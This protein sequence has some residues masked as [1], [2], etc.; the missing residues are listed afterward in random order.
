MIELACEKETRLRQLVEA[1]K[2]LKIIPKTNESDRKEWIEQ[3]IWLRKEL[4]NLFQRALEDYKTLLSLSGKNSSLY[5]TAF[6]F[7]NRVL[8]SQE[9]VI[10]HI[11]KVKRDIG[12]LEK[13]IAKAERE[14]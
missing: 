13:D 8:P 1:E 7:R 12:T 2:R 6:P 9:E 5:I 4:L 14:L 10:L 11:S 3:T